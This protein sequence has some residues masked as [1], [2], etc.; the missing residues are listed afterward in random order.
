MAALPVLVWT[1]RGERRLEDL[2]LPLPL[3]RLAPGEGPWEVELGFGK[4]RH[5][6][7]R[8]AELADHRYLGLE[9]ASKYYRMVRERAARRSLDNVVLIRGEAE[10]LLA[11]ALPSRFV[12][13]LH[14]YFPDPWPKSRHHR[15]RFLD[16][17][18]VDLVV[19]LLRPGGRMCFATDHLD[20]GE[21]VAALLLGHPAL[22]GRRLT[23]PWPGGPRTNY[24]AKYVREGRPILRLELERRAGDDELLH[25]CARA[26]VACAWR[27]AAPGDAEEAG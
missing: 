1:A 26:E 2:D 22:T 21:E 5:L 13:V 20:Y 3:D 11:T 27:A 16:A 25:P 12:E 10:Y 23:A 14:V 19:G 9:V 8:A 15:R 4:G 24:E 6:L 17:G 7:R 18:S